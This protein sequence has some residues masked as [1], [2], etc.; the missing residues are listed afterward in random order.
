MLYELSW[1]R[2]G[3]PCIGARCRRLIRL[4]HNAGG[5]KPKG[6]VRL[7]R[8]WWKDFFMIPSWLFLYVIGWAWFEKDRMNNRWRRST[9]LNLFI[10]DVM[11]GSAEFLFICFEGNT[12]K[13]I[14]LHF[15]DF[16]YLF[17]IYFY[18]LSLFTILS[19]LIIFAFSRFFTFYDFTKNHFLVLDLFSTFHDFLKNHHFFGP[20]FWSLFGPVFWSLLDP[21]LDPVF[22]P[23]FGIDFWGLNIR[24]STPKT[25]F[26]RI[27][28]TPHFWTRMIRYP[29][30]Y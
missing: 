19:K 27:P 4:F 2:W 17:V 26:S 12:I 25:S 6:N 5:T 28:P 14:F 21:V 30:Y 3:F 16:F 7:S 22:W 29:S 23:F 1:Y 20:V 18:F 24:L 10:H 9:T 8:S 15:S 13:M 11:P